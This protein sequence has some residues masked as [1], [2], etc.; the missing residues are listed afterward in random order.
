MPFE[1]TSRIYTVSRHKPKHIFPYHMTVFIK[2]TFKSLLIS[3]MNIVRK[4]Q[5][6]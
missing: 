4:F 5:I 3:F 6:I 2:A 1:F